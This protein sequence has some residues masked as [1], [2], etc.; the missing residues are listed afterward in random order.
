M[1]NNSKNV[2]TSGYIT[3]EMWGMQGGILQKQNFVA[4]DSGLVWI[5]HQVRN[6]RGRMG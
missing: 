1:V 3:I 2:R 5:L 4:R 6:D